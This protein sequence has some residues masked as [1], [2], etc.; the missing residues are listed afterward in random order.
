MFKSTFV[1]PNKYCN[2]TKQQKNKEGLVVNGCAACQK[3]KEH[4]MKN[5]VGQPKK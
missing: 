3:F 1:C 5:M 4:A 2:G